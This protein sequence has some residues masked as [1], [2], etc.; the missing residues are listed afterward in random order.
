MAI[1]YINT[2]RRIVIFLALFLGI[3]FAQEKSNA[4]G[5]WLQG[6][7]SGDEWWGLDYKLLLEESTFNA[8][9][10]FPTSSE[11]LAVG[12]YAGYYFL[13]PGV[14]KADASVG[15]FPL[16]FG[17]AVGI[18]YWRIDEDTGGFAVRAGATGGISWILPEVVVP[19]DISFELNPAWE[20][21]RE[22]WK[23]GG[24]KK[25]KYPWEIP[26]YFR[27]LFHAYLF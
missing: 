19:M 6:G 1:Y 20:L 3:S 9:F 25:N 8:Y 27:F 7:N 18:G 2:M 24:E 13:Y 22:Y 16:Y 14:I 17:P 10:R 12:L 26:L 5:L 4:L 15:K 23:E 11:D 21:R